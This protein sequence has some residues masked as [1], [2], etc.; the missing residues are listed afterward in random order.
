MAL[1]KSNLCLVRLKRLVSMII[2]NQWYNNKKVV[3]AFSKRVA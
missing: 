3:D 1:K 2:H